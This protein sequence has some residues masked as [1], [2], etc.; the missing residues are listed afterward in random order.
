MLPN[1]QNVEPSDQDTVAVKKYD[2]LRAPTSPKT[3][4]LRARFNYDKSDE[5][6]FLHIPI[7]PHTG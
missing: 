6:D 3:A 5:A 4:E 1:Q 2:L 7:E